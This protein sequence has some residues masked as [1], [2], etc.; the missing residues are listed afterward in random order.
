MNLTTGGAK[1]PK[2]TEPLFQKKA[3]AFQYL[4][5]NVNKKINIG[6]FQGLIWNAADS[7]NR[8]HLEWQF[9]N[10]IIFSNLPFYG[11]NNKNNILLGLTANI[12]LTHKISIYGQW[13]VDDYSNKKS[14]GNGLGGQ[15][16]LKYF[17]AFTLKN[18]MLQAEY[19]RV[20]ET[21][22]NNPLDVSADQ[23]FS[24]YNQNLA[25]TPSYGKELVLLGDYKYKRA[26]LNA[27]LNLQWKTANNNP[28]YK[29]TLAKVQIGY[30]INPSYNFNV[31]LGFNY[32]FQDFLEFSSSNNKTTLWSVSLK[33][34]LYNLYYDF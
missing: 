15:I 10:P 13:M 12:K 7:T 30:T 5:Y 9:F 28:L 6:L 33:T 27:K 16:G 25:F 24:H 21:S 20:A 23:S 29:N 26:F 4:S 8:Q 2:F 1:T 32:R 18:L 31:S 11:L 22:Y 17:D 3:G 34:N 19:N 14:A